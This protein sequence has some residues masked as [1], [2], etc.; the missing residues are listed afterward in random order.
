[1]C[2]DLNGK[3]DIELSCALGVCVF[4]VDEKK[5]RKERKLF[6]VFIDV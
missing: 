5:L 3:L 2:L 1:V 6:G 4:G